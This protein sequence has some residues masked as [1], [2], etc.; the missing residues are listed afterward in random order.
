MYVAVLMKSP[1]W[2]WY[3]LYTKKS[4]R[5]GTYELIYKIIPTWY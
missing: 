3:Y 1:Q 2:E 4:I 5:E